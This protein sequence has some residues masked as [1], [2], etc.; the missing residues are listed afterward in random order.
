MPSSTSSMLAVWPA[1]TFEKFIF[2]RC[3]QIRP[4]AV[5]NLS[6]SWKGWLRFGS[7]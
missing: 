7:R 4:Q 2:L 1:K 6:R 3:R 5:T